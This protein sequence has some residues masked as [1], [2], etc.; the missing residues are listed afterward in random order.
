M[1]DVSDIVVDPDLA[2]AFTIYRTTGAFG[3]GGWIAN[4]PTVVPAKGVV[5]VVNEK[6]LEMIPEGD[7]VK[8]AMNFYTTTPINVTSQA[9]SNI[10]D[11]IEWKGERYRVVSIAPW[12]S[13]G[14]Y[15]ATG[16]R[17]EGN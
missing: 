14:F 5:T 3:E 2:E 6:E 7:R 15:K 1:I 11:E 16:V 17:M 4:E 10:S 9:G 8:G 12:V 13:F